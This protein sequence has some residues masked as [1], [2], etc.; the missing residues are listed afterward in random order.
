MTACHSVLSTTVFLPYARLIAGLLLPL[1]MIPMPAHAEFSP[2]AEA[3]QG[4]PASDAMANLPLAIEI[5][6]ILLSRP[7]SIFKAKDATGCAFEPEAARRAVLGPQ[8]VAALEE[9]T[10]NHGTETET[11]AGQL[12]LVGSPCPKQALLTGLTEYIW[13]DESRLTMGNLVT[14]LHTQQRGTARYDA[15]GNPSRI[16]NI[17]EASYSQLFERQPSG[18]LVSTAL[19]GRPQGQ[20]AFSI[21]YGRGAIGQSDD[22]QVTFTLIDTAPSLTPA[23]PPLRSSVA[24]TR[25][26]QEGEVLELYMNNRLHM[27]SPMNKQQQV[28]G[29]Y[30]MF[31]DTGSLASRPLRQCYQN[32]LPAAD[33]ACAGQ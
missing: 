10:R 16:L 20:G 19:P 12:I 5:F 27:R 32:G 11:L 1:G 33:S 14:L 31:G 2:P 30:E 29:W 4:M 7:E 13:T 3:F 24:I 17:I 8:T 6:S 15:Q 28:H 9:E 18:E 21:T 23:M 26:T 25:Y 22:V